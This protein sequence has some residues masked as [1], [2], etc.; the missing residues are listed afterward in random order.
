MKLDSL[1]LFLKS[2]SKSAISE[3]L[4]LSLNSLDSKDPSSF[5]LQIASNLSITNEEAENL[6]STT[7]SFVKK[8]LSNK[9]FTREGI[10]S[11]FPSDF[12]DQLRT[13]LAKQ[14]SKLLPEFEQR[15]RSTRSY[16]P[17]LVQVSADVAFSCAS[18]ET[19]SLAVPTAVVDLNLV[20]S[21]GRNEDVEFEMNRDSLGIMVKGLS[22][23]KEQLVSMSK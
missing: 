9:A 20:D 18:S 12:H 13:L 15:T 5:N 8:C 11:T 22:K 10:A 14:L 16:L 21:N 7:L 23:I 3:C 2:P 1:L 4:T 19:S 17:R 6:R